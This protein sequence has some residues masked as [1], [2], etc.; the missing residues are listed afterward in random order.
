MYNK[1]IVVKYL[2]PT[3]TKGCRLKALDVN[4]NSITIGYPY[5]YSGIRAARV[6]AE[7]LMSKMNWK[8]TLV[9]GILKGAYVF[10]IID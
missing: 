5:E 2:S 8:G 10:I 9:E 1:T 4:G 6:A 7:K 3:N